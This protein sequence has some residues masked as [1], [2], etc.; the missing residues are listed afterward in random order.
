MSHIPT[1]R[2]ALPIDPPPRNERLQLTN[3]RGSLVLARGRR[4]NVPAMVVRSGELPPF[5]IPTIERV[6]S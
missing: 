5:P 3:R 6:K 4:G 1:A 2:H